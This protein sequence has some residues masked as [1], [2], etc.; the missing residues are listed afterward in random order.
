MNLK[1]VLP[2]TD[3]TLVEWFI[4]HKVS[5]NHCSLDMAISKAIN[6]QD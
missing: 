6:S 2:K 3:I 5:T 4:K 1:V